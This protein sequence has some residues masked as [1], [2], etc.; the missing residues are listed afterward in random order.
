MGRWSPL[1]LPR[2]RAQ[3]W[4]RLTDGALARL[5]PEYADRFATA[6][7]SISTAELYWTTP[8]MAALAVSAGASLPEVCFAHDHRPSTGGLLVWDGGIGQSLD[9]G[10][11]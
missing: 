7:S 1:A 2:A 6:A 5:R 4:S 3:T 8:D 10:S 11:M 9:E